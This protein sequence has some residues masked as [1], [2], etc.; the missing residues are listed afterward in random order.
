MN[1][2]TETYTLPASWAS[3]LINGDDSGMDDV[4]ALEVRDWLKGHPYLGEAFSCENEE[5]FS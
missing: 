4:E 2:L 5:E 1:L 3:Y